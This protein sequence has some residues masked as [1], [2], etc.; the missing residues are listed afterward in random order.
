MIF[1]ASPPTTNTL[2]LET[3]EKRYQE[4]SQEAS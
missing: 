1:R 4:I 3:Y 2:T